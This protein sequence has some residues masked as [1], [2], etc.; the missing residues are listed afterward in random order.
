MDL[1][2]IPY[3]F[4]TWRVKCLGGHHPTSAGS[5]SDWIVGASIHPESEDEVD[6]EPEDPLEV[7]LPLLLLSF[8]LGFGLASPLL[9]RPSLSACRGPRSRSRPPSLARRA[10]SL[11]P[12]PPR[13]SPLL[14][15]GSTL[16]PP[17][18]PFSSLPHDGLSFLSFLPLLSRRP[19]VSAR[20]VV[21]ARM[22][23]HTYMKSVIPA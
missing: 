1:L 9:P 12:P 17:S 20:R 23:A 7:V 6:D 19:G 13:P 8:A 18:R 5:R 11:L 21:S 15:P 10:S 14:L 16:R 2:F 22:C 3:S 4:S